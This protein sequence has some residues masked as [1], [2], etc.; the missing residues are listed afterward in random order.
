SFSEL[1]LDLENGKPFNVYLGL[2]KWNPAE[3]NVTT[4]EG[5]TDLFDIDTRYT[6]SVVPAMVRD[7]YHGGSP[8]EIRFMEHALKIFW[9]SEIEDL[10]EYHLV[11]IAQLEL[12]GAE[13]KL[14]E[15][16]IPPAFLI[17]SSKKL[18]QILR[19]IFEQITSRSRVFESYKIPKGFSS[20]DF[21][22][23]F[24]PH[25]LALSALN[26]AMPALNHIIE[27]PHS[28]PWNVYGLLRQIVGELSTFTDRITALGQLRDGT[29]LL[30]RYDHEDLGSCF[31]EAERLI[32]EC[33]NVIAITGENLIYLTREGNRFSCKI[34]AEDFKSRYSYTLIVQTAGDQ[35]QIVGSLQKI[36]KIGSFEQ[37]QTMISR[38][39][40][41]VPL[42]HRLVPPPGLPKRPD[43]YYFKLDSNSPHW[44]EIINSRQICL[45][46]DEAPDDVSVELAISKT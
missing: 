7:A 40:P 18:M 28:H 13:I 12:A 41:G 21:E 11:P 9:G 14:T 2:R 44:Q 16:F 8:T 24:L 43:S 38:A 4:T 33:L 20:S 30:P 25:L 3:K 29:E 23:H 10:G 6:S 19:N 45:Y 37:I 31:K 5:A 17:S 22:A 35:E 15:N 1:P 39:L 42:R 26:R 36:A 32:E 46:W 34:E 27:S